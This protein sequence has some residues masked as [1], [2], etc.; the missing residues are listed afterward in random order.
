MAKKLSAEEIAELKKHLRTI[1]PNIT[2]EELVKQLEELSQDPDKAREMLKTTSTDKDDNTLTVS[3]QLPEATPED[4]NWKDKVREA[5]NEA[6]TK[7]KNTFKEYQEDTKHLTFK[8]GENTISFSSSNDAYVEGEQKAFDELVV[9]AQK[10]EKTSISFGKF[11]KHPEYK[12]MLYLACL[13]HGMKMSDAPELS[14]L[15]SIDHP[16]A[17]EAFKE[18]I[19]HK[20]TEASKQLDKARKAFY[21]AVTD[22]PPKEENK[23]LKEAFDKIKAEKSKDTPDYEE[24]RKLEEKIREHS[25]GKALADAVE[26]KTNITKQGIEYDVLDKEGYKN[27][28]SPTTD[29][30]KNSSSSSNSMS[31]SRNISQ[32]IIQNAIKS[33]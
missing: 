15:A 5:I 9:A 25:L 11:E 7:L 19:K 27:Y 14:E 29:K 20:Y 8:D 6:N 3:E 21:M 22:N 16:Q 12:A 33:K 23:E 26:N 28:I 10:M 13:K 32:M 24:I 30:A 18:I 1:E 4:G 2:D 31:F 17:E